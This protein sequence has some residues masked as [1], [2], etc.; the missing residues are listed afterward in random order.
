MA[1]KNREMT[2]T[3]L[4][5]L[6]MNGRSIKREAWEHR[7][8][9]WKSLRSEIRCGDA[10]LVVCVP[11]QRVDVVVGCFSVVALVRV[12]DDRCDDSRVEVVV[13]IELIFFCNFEVK[14]CVLATVE[15]VHVR[16]RGRWSGTCSW[17]MIAYTARCTNVERVNERLQHIPV[18]G[19]LHAIPKKPNESVRLS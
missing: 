7:R 14:I 18:N 3:K 9:A 8:K 13:G 15:R 4:R 5:T 10:K 19:F 16:H 6:V 17:S 1:V 2:R 11:D 12:V